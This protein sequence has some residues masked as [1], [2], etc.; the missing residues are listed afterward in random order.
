MKKLLLAAMAFAVAG[1]TAISLVSVAQA[2]RQVKAPAPVPPPV[3]CQG[4]DWTTCFWEEQ[5]KHGGG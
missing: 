1:L 4:K 5:Q 2:H 3:E